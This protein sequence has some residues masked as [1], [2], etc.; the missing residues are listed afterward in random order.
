MT[1]SSPLPAPISATMRGATNAKDRRAE[2]GTFF[3]ENEFEDNILNYWILD[4]EGKRYET[5]GK[6]VRLK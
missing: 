1:T 4:E 3:S 5:G 2:E 6:A